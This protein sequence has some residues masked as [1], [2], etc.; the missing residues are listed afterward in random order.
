MKYE[1][2]RAALIK[3][4]GIGGMEAK[5]LLGDPDFILHTLEFAEKAVRFSF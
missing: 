4:I 3:N 5:K 2:E 1:R